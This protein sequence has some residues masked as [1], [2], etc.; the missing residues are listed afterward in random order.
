MKA[1]VLLQIA[2]NNNLTKTLW[3]YALFLERICIIHEVLPQE[4]PGF[5]LAAYVYSC[6]C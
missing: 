1:I 5:R 3:K 4:W 6:E 2:G